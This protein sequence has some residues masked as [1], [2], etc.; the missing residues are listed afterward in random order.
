MLS[1]VTSVAELSRAEEVT[2]VAATAA[3]A[4]KHEDSKKSG[5]AKQVVCFYW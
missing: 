1:V 5:N 2:R 4:I 3:D